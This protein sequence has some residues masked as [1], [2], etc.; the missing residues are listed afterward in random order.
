VIKSGL[1]PGETVVADG[2]LNLVQ[3]SRVAVKQAD[4]KVAP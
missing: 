2:Q 4:N 1:T 3:G